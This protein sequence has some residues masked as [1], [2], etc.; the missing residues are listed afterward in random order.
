MSEHNKA[1][2][3]QVYT[4]KATNRVSWF[5]TQAATSLRL[6]ERSALS[7]DAPIIDVGGGASVLVD[8]LLGR[9]FVDVSVLD[10]SGAA[11]AAARQRLGDV[12]QAV[13]WL[14][15]DVTRVELPAAHYA[16]W[17]DR[18]V[19]HFLTDP[20]DRAAYRQ[21]VL[22]ALRPDGQ[23][24]V[25]TFAENGPEKCSGLPVQRYSVAQ[26]CAEFGAEFT[27]LH[28]ETE[29]HSTP[30]GASQAFI[31]VQLQRVG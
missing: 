31:Y 14:E 27:L 1:H 18:A 22:H 20:A 11:L 7:L 10:L 19:F 3:E 25:A 2:W 4:T 17:H 29:T 24:I 15:A 13:T 26:L 12:A 16:L 30:S 6:I 23:V 9:G 8:D 28:H 21:R 5:Q